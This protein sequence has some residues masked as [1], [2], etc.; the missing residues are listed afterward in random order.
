MSKLTQKVVI[1]IIFF[2]FIIKCEECPKDYPILNYQ[3]GMCTM[4]YCTKSQF[5]E[6][7]CVISNSI[8]KIQWINSVNVLSMSDNSETYSNVAYDDI[9]NLLFES[10]IDNDNKLFFS[11]EKGGNSYKNK[12]QKY[13]IEK[14]INENFLY[15]LYSQSILTN[16]NNE[17]I[18]FS[19]SSNRY[20][21]IFNLDKNTYSE[22]DVSRIFNQGITSKYNSLLKTDIA[23]NYIYAYINSNN[24]MELKRLSITN[25]IDTIKTVSESSFKSIPRNSCKCKYFPIIQ[26]NYLY[27]YIECIDIDE[28]LNY[29]IR[30]YNANLDNKYN[31]KIDKYKS[32]RQYALYS[33]HEIIFLTNGESIFLYYNDIPSNGARPIILL[34]K[35]IPDNLYDIPQVLTKEELFTKF[36][37]IYSD[38]ENAL[39]KLTNTYFVLA[40]M[41]LNENK[42]LLIA[43]FDY[44]YDVS[45][46][47]NYID[48]PLKDLYNI[49]Y[50]SNLYVFP[51]NGIIGVGYTEEK[52]NKYINSFILFGY[53]NTTDPPPLNISS[54]NININNNHV[55]IKPADYVHIIN[56]I[57]SY[58]L[59]SIKIISVPEDNTGI[60]VKKNSTKEIINKE[61]SINLDEYLLISYT[62]PENKN[63][64][65]QNNY[66]I[67]FVPYLEEQENISHLLLC[68]S[69]R[70]IFGEYI[71]DDNENYQWVPEKYYGRETTIKINILNCYKNCL[72]CTE[73]S[74]DE[75]NQKCSQCLSGYFFEENT[76]NCYNEP[77]K[78][79]YYN[80][81]KNIFTQCYDYCETCFAGGNNDKHNCLSCKPE[82]LLYNSTNCLECKKLNLYVEYSQQFCIN[83]IPEGYYIN[84]TEYNTINKCHENCHSC[85]KG[86]EGNN[87]NCLNC[88]YTKN[89]FLVENTQNCESGDKEGYYLNEL[90][91][92]I[93]C[94][95]LCKTCSKGP[96]NNNMNCD[97]C[98]NKLGYFLNGT[99]CEFKE[100]ENKYYIPETNTYD[101]CYKNCL[102]C[103]DKE[104]NLVDK[105]GNNY[106]DMNCL[107]CDESN[108][109]FLFS[110]TGNNCLNCKEQ[111][112]YIN[113]IQTDCISEIPE[114]Y[115]LSNEDTNEID[116]CYSLCK[117]CSEKGTSSNDMKC[118]S[119]FASEK[120]KY[121][122]YKGNCLLNFC[123]DFFY[124]E[125]N[126]KVCLNNKEECPQFLPFY[127]TKNL[128]K[129]CISFCSLEKILGNGCK[130]ANIEEGLNKLMNLLYM[131]YRYE[132][133]NY[134]ENF[135][136]YFYNNEQI[137]IIKI[138]LDEFNGKIEASK[139]K[140]NE[141]IKR[142]DSEDDL[143]IGKNMYFDEL[144]INLE[145]CFDILNINNNDKIIMMKIDIKNLNLTNGKT[146]LK[147]YKNN[148]EIDLSIC[149]PY[150]KI[151]KININELI[152]QK[153][154]EKIKMNYEI[155]KIYDNNKC[156]VTYNDD[157][158]DL[159]L[160]DRLILEYEIYSL[161][162]NENSKFY[163]KIKINVSEICPLQS[164]LIDFD[165][166]N[167]N[168]I[169]SYSIDFNNINNNN[170]TNNLIKLQEE[171]TYT[172][173]NKSYLELEIEIIAPKERDISS[174]SNIKYMKCIS[175]ISSEFKNNY[176]IIILLILD[177]TYIITI[178]LYFCYYRKIYLNQFEEKTPNKKLINLKAS[179]S[180]YYNKE[181]NKTELKEVKQNKKNNN[182]FSSVSSDM[183][184]M[185][186][187]SKPNIKNK[188]ITLAE[189]LTNRHNNKKLINFNYNSN[190][191]NNIKTNYKNDLNYN[192]NINYSLSKLTETK[193]EVIKKDYDLSDYTTASEKDIRSYY[194]IFIS[195]TKKKQIYIF[196]FT[197]DNYIRI[198]KISLLI[199]SLINYYTTNVFFFNDKVI[200][201]I[202]LDK[203]SY[204]F[205]YQI[206]YICLSALISS[207]FLY[208]AKYIFIVKQNDKE[209][210]QIY[211]CIDLTSAIIIFLFI[212]YWL[213][214]GSYTSVF[215][216]SQKHISINFLITII[217]CT[218]YEFVLTIISLILRKIAIEK[219][220]AKIYKIS[221]LLILL[222][223]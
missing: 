36:N 73:Q 35:Y 103:F 199:F 127:N 22:N 82:R 55:M 177:I 178:F 191:N 209:F 72:T 47:I 19:I 50:Y 86:P 1:Y 207:I 57:F 12:N 114:G 115:F 155:N 213:Y 31:I 69:Y 172:Y 13:I 5:E 144:E 15:Q 195:L 190:N 63:L 113:F 4:E 56:N 64:T 180:Y 18:F 134:Y 67:I 66:E 108:N 142:L 216:K 109:F 95:P 214:V 21:N 123:P 46:Y 77:R 217:T 149:P 92:L 59:K 34:K 146:I 215:I 152:E 143:Y 212:F 96:S 104:Q 203:G 51:Y 208:L 125:S 153:R 3:K 181:N 112:K 166:T 87:M 140:L 65:N 136:S 71:E 29:Y 98:D 78:G 211:K 222:K 89:L 79:F 93:K 26:N 45:L 101:N 154:E 76:H 44:V 164:Y 48:I 202:Y 148:Q 188:R 60:I 150:N 97:S 137:F 186:L 42:H 223:A 54:Q 219:E 187:K 25:K 169:C 49:N 75:F 183:Q 24:N 167:N 99:N 2:L 91:I 163:P 116:K 81:N 70:E 94:H 201:Q 147:L 193:N 20:F 168:A 80:S 198:L 62:E 194:E 165:Y 40:T 131:K 107:R 7:I 161:Y 173:M 23:Y 182:V 9:Q 126:E 88:D 129:E 14:K 8:I 218:I 122:L 179:F 61:T 17:R 111:N 37:Y 33:F 157:G 90:K 6:G 53:G 138:K 128:T 117:S 16:D 204:N 197:N 184:T 30:I 141:N 74:N 119:C 196:A 106:L 10:I 52:N 176:V 130:I 39:T 11:M 159:L 170:I 58:I 206:K 28:S 174:E 210:K 32:S 221:L 124:Y 38:T 68:Y 102:F 133:L 43:L 145:E 162:P 135:F 83:Y 118:D 84:N 175:N 120:E 189:E 121:F 158:A 185:S 200:H 220:S 151:I 100:I 156:T 205:S 110:K 105:D 160:E 27:H 132:N 85:N 192:N 41:T 139:I 171:Y